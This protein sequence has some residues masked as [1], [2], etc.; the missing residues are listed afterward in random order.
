MI[1]HLVLLFLNVKV[2]VVVQSPRSAWFFAASL[3]CS[4]PG[5]CVPHHLKFAQVHVHCI[6]DAIQPSC[7]LMSSSSAW[8]LSQHQGL[9]QWLGCSHQ[10][11]RLRRRREVAQSCPTLS[12]SLFYFWQFPN[13]RFCDSAFLETKYKTRQKWFSIISIVKFY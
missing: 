11:E 13:L 8:N 7:P 5:R 9:F 12:E 3:D 10:M 2:V 1:K 4:T 6:H